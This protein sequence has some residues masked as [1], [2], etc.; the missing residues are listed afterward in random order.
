VFRVWIIGRGSRLKFLRL[1]HD[2]RA[3]RSLESL[4]ARSDPYLPTSECGAQQVIEAVDGFHRGSS[5][6]SHLPSLAA[7]DRITLATLAAATILSKLH[8]PLMRW[9]SA[10]FWD[11]L[12]I[13][14]L[15]EHSPR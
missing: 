5:L 4:N 3:E 1:S 11:K 10:N 12:P 13:V 8:P 2:A 9:V 15:P 14:A 7:F 6:I